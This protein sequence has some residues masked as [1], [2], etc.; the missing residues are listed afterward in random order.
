MEFT[1]LAYTST[2]ADWTSAE[3][4]VHSGVTQTGPAEL[5]HPTVYKIVVPK[6]T[7][8]ITLD[9]HTGGTEAEVLLDRG[10][11]YRVVTD[12]G[13]VHGVRRLDV[14]VVYE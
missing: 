8:A 5:I 10:L 4:L 13:V 7:A 14:E 6:G 2:S 12:H 11:R 3:N 1:S 9:E